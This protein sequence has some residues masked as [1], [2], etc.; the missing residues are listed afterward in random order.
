MSECTSRTPPVPSAQDCIVRKSFN[1]NVPAR[2]GQKDLCILVH[3]DF[4][5]RQKKKRIVGIIGIIL[6]ESC[7]P[8]MFGKHT[9]FIV[10]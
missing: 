7:I 1:Q 6:F 9:V 5:K 2:N 10:F 3:K 8:E 4:K